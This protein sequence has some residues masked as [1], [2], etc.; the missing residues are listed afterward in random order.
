M[1]RLMQG[2][3]MRIGVPVLSALKG[4]LGEVPATTT[5]FRM[6]EKAVIL[7]ALFPAASSE[8]RS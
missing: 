8:I 7:P 6:P 4:I 1:V 5:E 2:Y 3:P